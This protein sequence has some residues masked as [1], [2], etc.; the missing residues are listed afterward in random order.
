MAVEEMG[1]LRLPLG[2]INVGPPQ[3]IL[4]SETDWPETREWKI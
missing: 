1:F 2:F 3:E 4:T